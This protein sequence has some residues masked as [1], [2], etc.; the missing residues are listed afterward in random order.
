[1]H[2]TRRTALL[3]LLAS[4]ACWASLASLAC[5]A[6]SAPSGNAP[7]QAA[8]KPPAFD[9]PPVDREPSAEGDGEQAGDRAKPEVP[10]ADHAPLD[11]AKMAA[12]VTGLNAFAA[13]LY[14]R[15]A[16][17]E[18]NR[19][20][21]PA[22]V[23][24]ALAMVHAGAKGATAEEIALALHQPASGA[25]LGAAAGALL[26]R[27]NDADAPYELAVADRLFG[28]AKVPFEKA[29]LDLTARTFRAPLETMDFRGAPGPSRERI[30]AWVEE[31]TKDRIKDLLPASGVTSATRLVL[32]NA[33]YF[34]AAWAEAFQEH[35]TQSG[36]FFT[37]KGETTAK[38]MARTDRFRIAEVP[39][40][41][42][43]VLELP[44]DGDSMS[45][46]IVLPDARGGLAAVEKS[47]T[48][49]RLAGWMSK[50]TSERVEVKLPKFRIEMPD[51]LMLSGI[52][53]ELG[54]RKAFDYAQADFTAIAPKSE[55]LEIS[56]AFHKAFIEVNEKG[57]E[58]AAATA[59]SMRAGAAMPTEPPKAFVCDHPFGFL[60]VDKKTDAILF[61]G[62]VSEPKA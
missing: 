62:R 36:P 21:S 60:I 23:S 29:Y 24:L 47:L 13:E 27:W 28:D 35:A 7:A 15:A 12:V 50:L 49:E 53:K 6:A 37:A 33:I 11:D 42:L 9:P 40:D 43:R 58:A 32:V 39:E 52:L 25:D 10:P 34:K 26:T 44:Y 18:G 30:N 46:V 41:K 22:S 14:V 17:G 51:P 5:S 2:T 56:E 16:A 31:Q 3:G 20:I 59:I 4:P 61:M 48:G 19:V 8:K 45:M 55:Q 57:T 54:I 1:M 38:M